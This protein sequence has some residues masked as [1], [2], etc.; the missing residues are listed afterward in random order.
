M[1]DDVAQVTYGLVC[2]IP[3][4]VLSLAATVFWLWM[5][6]D[7]VTNGP[8]EWNDKIIWVLV[9]VLLTFLGAL[10]YFFVRR[11]TMRRMIGK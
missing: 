2:M 7:C 6:I 5:L 9:I 1:P 3:F 11:P 4:I 8:S 10:L